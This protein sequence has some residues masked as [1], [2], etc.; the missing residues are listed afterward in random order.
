MTV[1]IDVFWCNEQPTKA[2]SSHHISW[3]AKCMCVLNAVLLMLDKNWSCAC[4]ALLLLLRKL[5]TVESENSRRAASLS[6]QSSPHSHDQFCGKGRARETFFYALMIG[7]SNFWSCRRRK[8]PRSITQRQTWRPARAAQKNGNPPRQKH[9]SLSKSGC[10]CTQAL[11][12]RS[13]ASL[14]I[15]PSVRLLER[16]RP[17]DY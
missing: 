1:N 9:F 5:W 17:A 15:R 16:F 4:C 10:R 6:S 14:S 3:V 11:W 8:M 12:V 13:P 2:V 7:V